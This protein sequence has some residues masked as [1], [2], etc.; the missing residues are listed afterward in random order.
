MAR[1][2]VGLELP[3]RL[4]KDM[5]TNYIERAR[6]ILASKIDVEPEL[7]NLYTLLVLV[8]GAD[9]SWKDIHDAWAIWKSQTYAVHKSLIPFDELS[10]DV[11]EMDAEYATAVR[12]TAE[13]LLNS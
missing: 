8:R 11:Q 6:I 7:L 12:E 5:T 1:K 13:E 2:V 3:L 10:A 4:N 9:T